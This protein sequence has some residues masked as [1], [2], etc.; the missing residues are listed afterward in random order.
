MGQTH[1]STHERNKDGLTDV[2]VHALL[3]RQLQPL[4]LGIPAVISALHLHLALLLLLSERI[5]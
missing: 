5:A 3:P 1:L 4:G 2:R